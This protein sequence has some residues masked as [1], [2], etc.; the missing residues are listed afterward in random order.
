MC[1]RALLQQLCTHS[2]FKEVRAPSHFPGGAKAVATC[3]HNN[4]TGFRDGEKITYK[5]CARAHT[6]THTHSHSQ[7]VTVC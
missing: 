7:P 4:R 6:R 1:G 5:T 2:N 3:T